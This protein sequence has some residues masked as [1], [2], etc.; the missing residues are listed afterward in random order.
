MFTD[1]KPWIALLVVLLSISGFAQTANTIGPANTIEPA[2]MVKLLPRNPVI[3]NVGPRTIYAQA[4]VPNAQYIGM[5]AE[6]QGIQALREAVKKLPKTRLIVLYCGC[7]PWDR[8]PNMA[9]A[10]NELEQLG[11]KNV[12]ALHLAQNFGANWVNQGYPIQSGMPATP[13]K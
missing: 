7:C 4:H 9:P 6:P 8:C 11:F 3:L 1:M 5:T 10:F 13:G 12:K 2:D